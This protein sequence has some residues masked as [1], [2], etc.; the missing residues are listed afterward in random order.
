MNKTDELQKIIEDLRY[1]A[2]P[3][4]KGQSGSELCSRA[5]DALESVARER[6]VLI[7]VITLLRDIIENN[8]SLR[9]EFQDWDDYEPRQ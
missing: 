6:A 3:D 2:M 8:M 4:H 7:D 1:A 5:A 9:S